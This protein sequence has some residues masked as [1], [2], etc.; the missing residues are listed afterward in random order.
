MKRDLSIG[1]FTCIKLIHLSTLCIDIDYFRT[2]CINN[3]IPHMCLLCS[4]RRNETRK[5]HKH[6]WL[7]NNCQHNYKLEDQFYSQSKLSSLKIHAHKLSTE[8]SKFLEHKSL[9]LKVR[10]QIPLDRINKVEEL[11]Y[12]LSKLSTGLDYLSTIHTEKSTLKN[13]M[14]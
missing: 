12:C 6:N 3:C 1:R 2:L 7:R 5:R 13:K 14:K 8:V 9:M 4:W 10:N 11:I